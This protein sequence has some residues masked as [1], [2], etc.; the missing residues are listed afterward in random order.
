MSKGVIWHTSITMPATVY[1]TVCK[2]LGHA[3]NTIFLQGPSGDD[4]IAHLIAPK[5]DSFG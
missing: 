5:W 4:Q 1:T 3:E 2:S